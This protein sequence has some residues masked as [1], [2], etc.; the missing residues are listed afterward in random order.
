MKNN[1]KAL[2]TVPIGIILLF[3]SIATPAA[4]MAYSEELGGV[5]EFIADDI[6]RISDANTVESAHIHSTKPIELNYAKND[7]SFKLADEGA[8]LTWDNRQDLS[9]YIDSDYNGQVI[10]ELK[11]LTE[12]DVQGIETTLFRC[13]SSSGDVSIDF[14]ETSYLS[15]EMITDE[16]TTYCGYEPGDIEF[17]KSD[18]ST[19][20]ETRNRYPEL[21]LETREF[22]ETLEIEFE[23]IDQREES[24]TTCGSP[25]I[26][27]EDFVDIP[28]ENLEDDVSEGI[29]EAEEIHPNVQGFEIQD[30]ESMTGNNEWGLEFE[31][32]LLEAE[33]TESVSTIGRCSCGINCTTNRYE[34]NVTVDPEEI[35]VFFEIEDVDKSI[36]SSGSSRNLGFI[37]SPYNFEW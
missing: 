29:E 19:E 5:S 9:N 20:F 27:G 21:A 12:Q 37:V 6:N 4:M 30:V 34:T 35:D 26:D 7:N 3:T 8:Q 13:R 10:E 2:A 16:V 24:R 1:K 11:S 17:I 15:G 31:S 18:V 32:D 22:L 14:S 23:D 33:A 36:F 25:P 28:A